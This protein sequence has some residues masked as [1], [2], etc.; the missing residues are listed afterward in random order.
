MSTT[1]RCYGVQREKQ[2]LVP[3]QGARSYRIAIVHC[4]A[5]S[6]GRRDAKCEGSHAFRQFV[7][8][9]TARRRKLWQATGTGGMV[10]LIE[11]EN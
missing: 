6:H 8:A 7:M 1:A 4:A 10:R 9:V 2:K 3:L 11:M 5:L